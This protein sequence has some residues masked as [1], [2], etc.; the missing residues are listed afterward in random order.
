MG[1]AHISFVVEY[2]LRLLLLLAFL[3]QFFNEFLYLLFSNSFFYLDFVLNPGDEALKLDHVSLSR[4]LI[5][6]LEFLNLDVGVVFARSC[7]VRNKCS[8][9]RPHLLLD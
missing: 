1:S 2:G 3:N 6:S 8:L 5:T 9:L 4:L 7:G